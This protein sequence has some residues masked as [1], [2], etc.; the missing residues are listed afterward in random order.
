MEPKNEVPTGK[1]SPAPIAIAPHARH[2]RSMAKSFGGYA[3][4]RRFSSLTVLVE[5]NPSKVAGEL[6]GPLWVFLHSK[7]NGFLQDMDSLCSS[8]LIKIRVW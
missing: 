8:P 6:V 3:E 1:P 7:N 4:S 5:K 2:D